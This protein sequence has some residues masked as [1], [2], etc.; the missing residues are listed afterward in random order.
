M[1][2]LKSAFLGF[3]GGFVGCIISALVFGGAELIATVTITTF[4][5]S[6]YGLS[7]EVHA[8]ADR[9]IAAQGGSLPRS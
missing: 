8:A 9:V 2:V 7:K 6:T 3:V 1:N 4:V 5:G